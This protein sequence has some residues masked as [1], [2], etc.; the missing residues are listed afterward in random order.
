MKLNVHKAKLKEEAK[1]AEAGGGSNADIPEFKELTIDELGK[2][3]M[4]EQLQYQMKLN[5]WKAAK[6]AAEKP[7]EKEKPS[8]PPLP[9]TKE[10]LAKMSMGE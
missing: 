5:V 10:Q 8:G 1:K 2:L 3:S 4:P 7:K 6:K 9:K